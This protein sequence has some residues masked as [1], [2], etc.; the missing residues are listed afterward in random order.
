MTSTSSDAP[1]TD[2]I[3]GAHN[4]HDDATQLEP[5]NPF[6]SDNSVDVEA[7]V[8]WHEKAISRTCG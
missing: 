4:K 6:R 3:G 7:V 8:C 5:S 1:L 2:Q